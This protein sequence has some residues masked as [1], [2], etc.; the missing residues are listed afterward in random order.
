MIE[1]WERK[2]K[3]RQKR[4]FHSLSLLP[5]SRDLWLGLISVVGGGLF[6]SLLKNKVSLVKEKAGFIALQVCRWNF[7]QT[8]LQ[9]I[10]PWKY[11]KGKMSDRSVPSLECF[12]VLWQNHRTKR[13]KEIWQ[14]LI[15]W[16]QAGAT[17]EDDAIACALSNYW[18]CS[19]L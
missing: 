12:Q 4:Q 1:T 7:L 6:L 2:K 13:E 16:V 18:I 8:K 15:C 11:K 17:A 19:S 14:G 9:D 5:G 3:K 10:I